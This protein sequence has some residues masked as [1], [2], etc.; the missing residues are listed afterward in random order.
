M[1]I[2]GPAPQHY[3]FINAQR[4]AEKAKIEHDQNLKNLKRMNQ[5]TIQSVE[6]HRATQRLENAKW[7]RLRQAR[8]AYLGE[9][10]EKVGHSET[11]KHVDVKV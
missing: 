8:E 5:Q 11:V 6:A 4:D 3:G 7:D 10:C 9:G 2:T 1:K